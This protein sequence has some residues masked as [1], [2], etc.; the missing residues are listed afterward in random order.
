[1]LEKIQ[2][3]LEKND[4]L[5]YEAAMLEL[6]SRLIELALSKY[7]YSKLA[8]NK[9]D[10]L[11]MGSLGLLK[12]IRTWEPAK[13][14]FSTWGVPQILGTLRL[15]VRKELPIY[16]KSKSRRGKN[17]TYPSGKVKKE[18]R[19]PEI[20]Y[21]DIV[22]LHQ[23]ISSDGNSISHLAD[24]L[25]ECDP[26]FKEIDNSLTVKTLTR[27]LNPREKFIFNSRLENNTLEELSQSLGI[28]RERVRQ[29]QVKAMRKIRYLTNMSK[30]AII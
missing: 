1:M 30:Y 23:P 16:H 5:T 24:T 11:A 4:N 12:A 9:D 7:G 21:R 13:G 22:S 20:C 2:N 25:G 27:S 19:I 17:Y 8:V 28:T 26:V 29:I 10:L 3:L 6:N 18:Y 15:G 14:K